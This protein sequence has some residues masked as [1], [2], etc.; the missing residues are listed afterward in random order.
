[1]F[2]DLQP[3]TYQSFAISTE[4]FA[5]FFKEKDVDAYKM[6]FVQQVIKKTP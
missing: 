1:V 5:I 6:F 4:N 3:G 2:N